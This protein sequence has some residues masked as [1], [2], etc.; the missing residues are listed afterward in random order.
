V[1]LP[2]RVRGG[3]VGEGALKKRAQAI[4]EELIGSAGDRF[5]LDSAV[6]PAGIDANPRS[7]E[8]PVTVRWFWRNGRVVEGAG[9]QENKS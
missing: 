9:L 2:F 5:N 4:A 1:E 3:I 8:R 6:L 7:L